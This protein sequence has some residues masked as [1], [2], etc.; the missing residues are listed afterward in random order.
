M[1]TNF[2]LKPINFDC[3]FF[4]LLKN[5]ISKT[6]RGHQ[7]VTGSAL[8]VFGRLYLTPKQV[9]PSDS[10]VIIVAMQVK[11]TFTITQ[12]KHNSHYSTEPRY[13]MQF[14]KLVPRG[15]LVAS[16][17]NE[18]IN[19]EGNMSSQSTEWEPMLG[20][21]KNWSL[22]EN[23]KSFRRTGSTDQDKIYVEKAVK[24]ERGGS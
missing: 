12:L 22:A 8:G 2:Y 3:Q 10:M 19:K 15:L 21:C 24:Q 17:S 18:P 4:L 5:C 13:S 14:M 1:E 20:W 16:I 23:C 9:I 7:G 6:P 11:V